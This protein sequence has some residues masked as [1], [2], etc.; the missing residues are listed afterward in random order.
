MLSQLWASSNCLQWQCKREGELRLKIGLD[1]TVNRRTNCPPLPPSLTHS[2][3]FVC[4]NNEA[5]LRLRSSVSANWHFN[6]AS[7]WHV[8]MMQITRQQ[9]QLSMTNWTQHAACI[10]RT[11]HAAAC[12]FSLFCSLFFRIPYE[13]EIFI[14]RLCFRYIS[15]IVINFID[16]C[17][18]LMA[19]LCAWLSDCCNAPVVAAAV[20][21]TC[22]AYAH[23]EQFFLLFFFFSVSIS[24]ILS[25]SLFFLLQIVF[26]E[27]CCTRRVMNRQGERRSRSCKGAGAVASIYVCI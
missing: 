5:S 18:I 25:L 1:L 2:F 26:N 23:S 15:W 16:N 9:N 17:H 13:N 24:A 21:A 22:V 6:H 12:S 4:N 7:I 10:H 27:N 19:W 3:D 20:V 14:G 11:L 8:F